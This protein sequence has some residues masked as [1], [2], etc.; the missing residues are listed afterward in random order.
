MV[1]CISFVVM[2]QRRFRDALTTDHH[3]EQAGFKGLAAVA[4]ITF[5]AIAFLFGLILFEDRDLVEFGR[6][7]CHGE[8]VARLCKN[9]N[10]PF[11]VV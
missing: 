4:A 2:K 6:Q 9:Y 8:F 5:S 10:H 11:L 3:F 1:D 7:P